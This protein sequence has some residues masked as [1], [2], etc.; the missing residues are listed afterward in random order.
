MVAC[1]AKPDDSGNGGD[2]T[3]PSNTGDTGNN[4]DTGSSGG[5]TAL[6]EGPHGIKYAEDQTLH[7]VYSC[8]S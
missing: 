3:S 7:L 8:S 6:A 5:D 4:N 2:T 1:G